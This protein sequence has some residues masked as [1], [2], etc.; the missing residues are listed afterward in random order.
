MFHSIMMG[1]KNAGMLPRLSDTERQAL[2]AGDVWAE[3]EFFGGNPDFKKLMSEAYNQLTAE[4][5]AFMDGP[6][7][8]L[9]QMCDPWEMS[10]TRQVPDAI[11]NYMADN[12]FF[13]LLIPKKYGGKGFSVLARSTIMAKIQA[14]GGAVAAIVVI[15]NSLGAAE[16]TEKYGTQEQKDHYLPR[17]AKG[18]YIPCFGLTEL[19]AGSDAA[20]IKADGVV[21]RDDDGHL[22]ARMSF[23]KRY[24][25]LAPIANLISLAVRLR[26]PDNLLGKGEDL[27]ITV[28]LLHKGMDGL[29][30]GL[31]HDPMGVS[32][33]N[34]PIYGENVVAPLANTIGGIDY[35]GKGWKMLMESLA[36]GRAIS[37]PASAVG[38]ARMLASVTGAY[39]MVREQFNMP[40]GLMEGP[41]AKVARLAGLQYL[42]E[43]ARV[44]SCSA[45]DAGHEPPVVSAILKQQLTEL[46][47]SLSIDAMDVMAGAAIQRGPNNIVSDAYIAAP[48]NI[49][50]EGA[51]ILT[52]TLIIYGQGANR[53]HPYARKL[54]ESVETEDTTRFRSALVGWVGGMVVNFGRSIAR[55]LT[56]GFTAGSP[57]SG[58]TATYYRRLGWASTRFAIL[59]DLAMIFMGAKL[60]AKGNFTGRLADVLSWIFLCTATLRRFEAEGRRAEDLPMVHYA[61][62]YG[63]KEIQDGFEGV[64]ANFEA[65]VVGWWFKSV[66]GWLLRLNPIGKG[67]TDNLLAPAAAVV[68]TPDA[69]LD[70]QQAGLFVPQDIER[71]A[72]RLYHA[73]RLLHAV[74]PVHAKIIAASKA[75]TLPKGHPAELIDLALEKQVISADEA[76]QARTARRVQLNSWAVDEFTPEEYV[77]IGS[78]TDVTEGF[79][80]KEAPRPKLVASGQA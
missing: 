30:I 36:G 1:M 37:L 52:R 3:G 5:Q 34:G 24:I 67:V 63:L 48:I 7:E 74:R 25:T 45:V 53:S 27:G 8:E 55:Y 59:S 80:G 19:T 2:E 16:L 18:E 42:M 4:E 70:A 40:I 26:D 21:F 38:G 62:N 57:V 44:Y 65:P 41:Q 79:I 68:Q 76:E 11:F 61:L 39:S 49:T 71:G 31:R 60:K 54:V 12:G 13:A 69:R 6:C 29:S 32:F 33:H 46:M 64:Y 73:F 77:R 75:K 9:I 43:A 22:K 72:G 56:R 50:V 51:N 15:P 66:G 10:R 20:S 47:R 14:A 35:V 58:E 28:M 23:S 78:S 17:L